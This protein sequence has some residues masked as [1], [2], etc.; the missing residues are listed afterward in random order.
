[1]KGRIA[2]WA[3]LAALAALVVTVQLDRQAYRDPSAIALVPK[4]MRAV[5]Q[6]RAL[7]LMLATGGRG[8]DLAAARH[9]V[10]LRPIPAHN[11]LLYAQT[12][13]LAGEA[14]AVIAP[15]EIA[16]ARGW[17]EPALQVLAGQAALASG[18]EAAAV[19]RAA[20][21][22]ATGGAQAETRALLA[23]IM[24]SPAGQAE[25]AGLLT[26]PGYYSGTIWS[27]LGEAGSPEQVLAIAAIARSQDTA[28]DCPALHTLADIWGGL[29]LE[30]EADQLVALGCSRGA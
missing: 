1:M 12:A 25:L 15:L 2:L 6:Q 29:H 19:Q 11:L 22:M 30:D 8:A 5:A 21:L 24:Q 23:G 16:A 4:P 26:R 3:C 7:E 17:R 13:Q 20:A 27:Y 28:L 18:D 14:D 9:L 10:R